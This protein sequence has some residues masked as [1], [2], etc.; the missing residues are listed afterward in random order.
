MGGTDSRAAPV[1][2]LHAKD[3]NSL[4]DGGLAIHS[5]QFK[6]SAS[7]TIVF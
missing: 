1:A 5:S 2:D 4:F 7:A 6:S 3:E